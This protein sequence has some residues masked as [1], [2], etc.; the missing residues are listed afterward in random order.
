LVD[1]AQNL[2]ADAA[3]AASLPWP[4][5]TVLAMAKA[6]RVLA[7]LKRDAALL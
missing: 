7:A 6:A 5:S 1:H 4:C 3:G 2:E